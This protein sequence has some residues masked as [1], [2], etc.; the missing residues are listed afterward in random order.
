MKLT[1]DQLA[2]QLGVTAQAVSKWENDQS[3][4]DITMLPRLAEIFGITTD[5]LLGLER[6]EVHMDKAAEK[7]EET[8]LEDPQEQKGLWELQWDVGRKHSLGFALW[9]LTVG[10][11]AMANAFSVFGPNGPSL[12]TLIRTVGLLVFGLMGLFPKFRFFRLGCALIGG[13][14]LLNELGVIAFYPEWRFIFPGILVLFGLS[15]LFDS[16]RRPKQGTFRISRN[17]KV[18]G[19]SAVN[20]CTCDGDTFSC[21]T[22]FGHND[23][24]IRL[25]RLSVG[26]AELSFGEMTVDLGGCEEIAEDC[27]I[28]LNCA[29]GQL[30]LLVPRRFR[31]EL[32]SETAFGS[33]QIK[34]EPLPEPEGILTV[35]C[36]VS[37]GQITV[38]Y[39]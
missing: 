25:P 9:V 24:P 12:R 5:A 16:L 8:E 20:G 22:S 39:I 28:G 17:G 18:I 37:F 19:S 4:P 10:I 21:A 30:T 31:A 34:G 35:Q 29:F 7:K 11:L 3:C 1:Q 14:F 33:V 26:N 6:K 15:L 13:Y 27:R 36:D 38:L 2:E 23:Y 32:V